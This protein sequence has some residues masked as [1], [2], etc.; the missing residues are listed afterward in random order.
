MSFLDRLVHILDGEPGL[1]DGVRGQVYLH[2][3]HAVPA[4]PET[5]GCTVNV[6]AVYSAIVLFLASICV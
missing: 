3:L 5:R 2:A 6:F 4:E 1:A